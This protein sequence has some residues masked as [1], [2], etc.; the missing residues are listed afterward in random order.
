MKKIIP[1]ALAIA[2]LISFVTNLKAQTPGTLTFSFLPTT[3]SPCYQGSRNV[4]AVWVQSELGGFVKTK[5]RY[6]GSST[7]DHLPTWAVNSGGPAG[8]CLSTLCNK[9]DATTGATLPSF[10]AKTFTWD[11]K[12]VS[13][14]SNGTVVAD[15]VYKVTIESTWNHGSGSTTTKTFTFTKGPCIDSQTPADDSYF[16]GVKLDWV[17]SLVDTCVGGPLPCPKS[18]LITYTCSLAIP[19]AIKTNLS[20]SPKVSIFP[21]PST[22]LITVDYLKANSI[23]V[24]NTLGITVYD[25]KLADYARGSK[26]VDLSQLSTGIYL[27]KVSNDKGSYTQKVFLSK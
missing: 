8:N 12:G 21:N 3:Q 18:P 7:S 4:L 19:D 25:E 24:I 6:A 10:T 23:T 1:S 13:G 17:P 14:A 26:I 27:V 2:L 22:G 20:L 16:T 9:T 5:F 15:G 11:G